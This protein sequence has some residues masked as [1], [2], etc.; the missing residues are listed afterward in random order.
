MYLFV[1]SF[2][3]IGS[4]LLH[5]NMALTP[6]FWF[7]FMIFG[8]TA[9]PMVLYGF[10]YEFIQ[11]ID[12]KK[13]WIWLGVILYAVIQVMNLKGM[14]VSDVRVING[15]VFRNLGTGLYFGGISLFLFL[16]LSIREIIKKYLVSTDLFE[17][18][19][20]SYL[21]YSILIIILGILTNFTFLTK[22]PV[23][24]GLNLI[25]ALI[26]SYMLVRYDFLE[27]PY[28]LRKFLSY[29]LLYGILAI[30]YLIPA[31]LMEIFFISSP[32][33]LSIW[34]SLI[35]ISVLVILA[36]TVGY[37]YT[38]L[39]KRID[40]WLFRD[41]YE[42]DKMIQE[43]VQRL[44]KTID[45]QELTALLLDH[46]HSFMRIT[47]LKLLVKESITGNFKGI[48]G[49][50]ESDSTNLLLTADHPLIQSLKSQLVSMA[51]KPSDSDY[52]DNSLNFSLLI[53][54][55]FKEELI[56]ILLIGEKETQNAFLENDHVLL[57]RIADQIALPLEHARLHA[58][59]LRRANE[60]EKLNETLKLE[61]EERK[62]AEQAHKES[63]E[64]YRVLV[65]M[66]PD[67]I[68][69]YGDE[70]IYY[71][72]SAG[73][74]LL[75]ADSQDDL[76]GKSLMDYIHPELMETF[77]RLVSR[78]STGSEVP[79]TRTKFV[80]PNGSVI[81]AEIRGT[82]IKYKGK[83]ATLGIARDLTE[84]IRAEKSLKES[85]ET[86]RALLNTPL[87]VSILIDETGKI[88]DVN[89][90]MLQRLGISRAQFIGQQILEFPFDNVKEHQVIQ[91]RKEYV[92]KVFES[93]Q[94]VRFEDEREGI[95]FDNVMNPIIDEGG[96]V[97][98]VVIRAHD[99]TERKLTEAK[100]RESES[101]LK[102]FFNAISESALLC[103]HQGTI[104]AANHTAAARFNR[105]VEDIIGLN[106]FELFP[107]DVKKHRQIFINKVLLGKPIHFEDQR[108][109]LYL[110]NNIYPVV[111]DSDNIERV[112]IVSKDITH[113]K[114]EEEKRL[115][116]EKHLAQTQKLEAV[117]T[118]AG[119]IAHD[120]NNILGTMTGYTELLLR[121]HPGRSEERE[122]IEEILNAGN[123]AADL[124][125]QILTFSRIDD[126]KIKPIL[127]TPLVKEAL[128]MVRA[129]I[130][131]TIEIKSEIKD[132]RPVKANATQIH[133]IIL[134]LCTNA[135]HAMRTGGC[136]DVELTEITLSAATAPVK[137][138]V[139][140]DYALLTVKDTG[141][142]ISADIQERIFEPFFT[143]KEV[144]KGTGL[145]LS[146]IHGIVKSCKG[147]IT[148]E[149]SYG[150]GT[151]FKVYLPISKEQSDLVILDDVPED[152][153][154]L[155]P[156]SPFRILLVEDEKKL[157][158]YYN[159]TLKSRGYTVIH[160]EDGVS[161]L[162]TFKQ[163]P[164][165]FDLVFTDQTMPQMTGFE[166]SQRILEIRPNIPI[167]LSTGYST[168][169]NEESAH[170]T[171]IRHFLF[172]PIKMKLLLGLIKEELTSS[173]H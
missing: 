135:Y 57:I 136:L 24:I 9:M 113:Q 28:Y 167:I 42:A 52:T 88:L 138:L 123:R 170:K 148:F 27:I 144:G 25:S 90:T 157:S 137:D 5:A 91:K 128:K 162:E 39:S 98:K 165:Q 125:Q 107:P 97:S 127:I 63:E 3:S 29:L 89:E 87:D 32:Y 114:K 83:I 133:Q 8:S 130:P 35:F 11:D 117:G 59:S 49:H 34:K 154:D 119:G 143:T 101:T 74:K 146:V 161:A 21:L 99:I 47:N 115:S 62:L 43:L 111:N 66:S 172:K 23:D 155:M 134:N 61:I 79:V 163:Q 6:E 95:W 65:E 169:I 48:E 7:R 122:F 44:N 156:G 139:Y 4:F 33:Q 18:R 151:M 19:Q 159:I 132:C 100:L 45:L 102:A 78:A 16:G 37:L 40:R 58:E 171:G 124:V 141:I 13:L 150:K 38:F 112:A 70:Q 103:S 55:K 53:P 120:F 105:S 68:G 121:R 22:Y 76:L 85:E 14:L 1:M 145:G 46:I 30:T 73:L 131:T 168:D 50:D 86:A 140:G 51:T 106:A 109:G 60:F 15:E 126:Q 104:L 82:S 93:G 80:Q 92:K 166:L 77:A 129:T 31:F 2:W 10:V 108:D 164:D 72:N 160:C 12:K 26:I 152:E 147:T 116:L 56:G 118:L 110:E 158:K 71:V 64:R 84:R 36:T 149:S 173:E 67:S 75:G 20:L 17:K 96:K 153:T 142:G 41:Q 69:V 94:L 54:V 81:E